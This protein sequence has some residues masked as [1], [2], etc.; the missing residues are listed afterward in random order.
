MSNDTK[1][2]LQVH[3][4]LVSIGLETPSDF[5]QATNGDAAHKREVIE[6]NFIEI[7]TVLGLDITND[8]MVDTPKRIAKMYVDEVFCGL[9]YKNFPKIMSFENSF[10]NAGLV[11]ERN[12]KVNSAC[13]HH[14]VPTI[15]VATIG[16]I[17]NKRV[18]GLSKLQRVTN[19]FSRRPQE[20]ERFGMQ[21]LEVM[22]YLLDTEDV[23]VI[24]KAKHYCVAWRGVQDPESEFITSH[25]SGSFRESPELRSEFFQIAM[26]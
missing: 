12:I 24:V 10:Q 2:G 9:D 3:E 6:K 21:L 14:F 7:M 5:T 25:I 8:S 22:K 19:F 17:P 26:Q 23:A 20:Q 16:Y 4:H 15:G 11:V 18:I 13:S 1:L